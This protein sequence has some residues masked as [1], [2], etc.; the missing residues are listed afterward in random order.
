[1]RGILE[2]G[3][4][5]LCCFDFGVDMDSTNYEKIVELYKKLGE[6]KDL[7][8]IF[9]ANDYPIPFKEF[10]IY[11]V[12]VDL[13]F[14]FHL[15]VE[16]LLLPHKTSGDINAISKSYLK[17]LCY[18]ATDKDQI[19]YISYL[20]ELLLIVLRKPRTYID[21]EGKE[22]F[23][24]S[25]I[26]DKGIIEIEGKTIDDKEFDILR[27]II[28]EQNAVEMLDESIS[29]ELLKAY[30]EREEYQRKQAQIKM[31]SFEDQINV[32][33]ARSAYRRD[34][35]VKM[36]IRSFSRLL[37]RTDKIMD[38][39]IKNLLSPYMDKK[40]QKKI[41]HYMEE[42]SLDKTLKE[43]CDEAFTDMES[44]HKKVEG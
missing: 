5:S 16:C 9:Y 23:T 26:L 7:R 44:L 34:E 22:Q 27:E 18:L 38:Y 19:Q 8:K 20:G 37:E 13:Y 29:P 36:T 25:I 32:V 39:E 12:Q 28:C 31:C 4:P 17:Y 41:A 1:M 30:K 11:P 6:N 35:V 43:K 24:V 42:S 10:T 40:D 15:F 2:D 3:A 21:A 14:Y 33:V